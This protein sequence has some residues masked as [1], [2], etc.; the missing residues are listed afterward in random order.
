MKQDVRGM[1]AF[2]RQSP[3]EQEYIPQLYIEDALSDF[4]A[5]IE[6]NNWQT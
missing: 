1:Y 3:E 2:I 6:K 5:V 4:Q